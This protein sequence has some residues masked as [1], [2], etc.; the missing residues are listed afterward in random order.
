MRRENEQAYSDYQA[1]RNNN[2]RNS[3]VP[4]YRPSIPTYCFNIR[5]A[6][7][8]KI[9]FLLKYTT[10]LFG[11]FFS[12]STFSQVY[13]EIITT[14]SGISGTYSNGPDSANFSLS[15]IYAAGFA[16]TF[17]WIAGAQGI[18]LRTKGDATIPIQDQILGFMATPIHYGCE[19]TTVDSIIFSQSA[20]GMGVSNVNHESSYDLSWTGGGLAV[21]NDPDDQIAVF[22]TGDLI[23]SGTTIWLC[24]TVSNSLDSWNVRVPSSQFTIQQKITTSALVSPVVIQL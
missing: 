4:F 18:E 5:S 20:Y 15:R 17:E 10:I 16:S 19:I 13:D 2:E 3:W 7:K 11:F 12:F 24:N 21:I 14:P 23:P 6:I 8:I 9:M 1:K 22:N